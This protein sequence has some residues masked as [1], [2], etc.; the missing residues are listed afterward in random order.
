MVSGLLGGPDRTPLLAGPPALSRMASLG[1]FRTRRGSLPFSR[2]ALGCR[3]ATGKRDGT[4][5]GGGGGGGELR[6]GRSD[7]PQR[8]EARQDGSATPDNS[9]YACPTCS[10]DGC[11]HDLGESPGLPRRPIQRVLSLQGRLTK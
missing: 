6:I 7:R 11:P 8:R 1:G 9:R 10:G 2:L 4:K 5:S 3:G